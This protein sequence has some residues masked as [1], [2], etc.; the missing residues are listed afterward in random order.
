MEQP[1]RLVIGI[2]SRALFDLEASHAVF[3]KDGVK[4]INAGFYPQI[5]QQFHQAHRPYFQVH[6]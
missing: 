2:A 1:N 6:E 4:A 5:P 3:E